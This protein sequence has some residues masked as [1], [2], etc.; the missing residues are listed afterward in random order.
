MS[1]VP[2]DEQRLMRSLRR[3]R[4]QL[5]RTPVRTQNQ[6]ESLLDEARI[7]SSSVV[8]DLFRARGLLTLAA[9][10]NGKAILRSYRHS[11]MPKY[12]NTGTTGGSSQ[13]R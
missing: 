3:R 5:T 1:F 13:A 12:S 6:V 7:K 10:V 11:P 2:D 9:L 4:K 8:T